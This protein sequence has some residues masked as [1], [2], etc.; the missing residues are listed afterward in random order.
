MLYAWETWILFPQDFIDKLR[1]NIILSD[2]QEQ[3]TS[4]PVVTDDKTGHD[5][6]SQYIV[7]EEEDLDGVPLNTNILPMEKEEDLDG[8][9]LVQLPTTAQTLPPQIVENNSNQS[10]PNCEPM[11]VEE[12][13][14]DLDGVPLNLN[15]QPTKGRFLF[16]CK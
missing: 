9:P 4:N 8:V 16:F 7:E 15:A 12:S 5:Q 13:D 14:E 2:Q 10:S 11:E 6:P 1:A 3:K